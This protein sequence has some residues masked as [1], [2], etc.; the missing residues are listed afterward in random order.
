LA[1]PDPRQIAN[2]LRDILLY[3]RFR[4]AGLANP[5]GLSDVVL[6]KNIEEGNRAV[7]A[8]LPSSFVRAAS[9]A[10]AFLIL[11]TMTPAVQAAELEGIMEICKNKQLCP[12]FKVKAKLPK[13]WAVDEE[14]TQRYHALVLFEDGDKSV[15]KPV[16]YVRAHAGEAKLA[17]DEY[18]KVAQARWKEHV[19]GMSSIEPLED[20]VRD[21]KPTFK[22]YLYKNP[23]VPEQAFELTAFTKDTT[24]AYKDREHNDQTVFFQAVMSCSDMKSLEKAKAAF[25]ELLNGI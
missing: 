19:P 18:I 16:I 21:G 9:A 17:L 15:S 7:S 24:K 11:P 14:W 10:L 3:R 20:V 2:F 23:E 12:W 1:K 25:Y 13:G 8:R 6:E 22:V 5:A 4:V